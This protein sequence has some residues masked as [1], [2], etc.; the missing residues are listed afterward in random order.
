M[1]LS[2]I[3]V[4]QHLALS[5]VRALAAAVQTGLVDTCKVPSDDCFQLINRFAADDMMLN[6]TFGGMART[7]DASI[8]EITLL[9]GRSDDQKRALYRCVTDLAVV[10]GFKADDI[11]MALTENATIDWTLGRGQSFEGHKQPGPN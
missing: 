5:Q 8:V 2:R 9:Q 11:M 6:P 10:A 3:S 7:N 4:P 1:P